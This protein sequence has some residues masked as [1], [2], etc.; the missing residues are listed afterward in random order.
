MGSS[1]D[2]D[3]TLPNVVSDYFFED[4]NDEP[5]SFAELPLK[6]NNGEGLDGNQK[7]IGLRGSTD[8]G[9]KK[10]FEQV[11]A[12]KF[13]ISYSKPEILVLTRKNNWIKLLKPRKSYEERI[14]KILI[15]LHCLNF[16]KRN[17]DTSEK[18]LWDYLAKVFSLYDGRPSE[19]DLEG[20][21][22]LIAEA[23]MRDEVLSRSKVL[24]TL[25]EAKPRKKKV[26]E[27]VGTTTKSS[28]IVD[29]VPN[30][31]D[32]GED[33]SDDEEEDFFEHVCAICDNGGDILCCEGKCMR[34]FHAT[35]EAGAESACESLGFSD[36]QVKAM[37]NQIF[38]C[39]NCQ[40][41]QHQC[42]V[43]GELGSSDK[44]AGA[45]VFQC[46]K[47]TCGYFYHPKC[48]A[49]ALRLRRGDKAK[50]LDE[51]EI[52]AGKSFVCP[53][54]YCS[55]CK[56]LE[57][58]GKSD[59]QMQFAVC[60]RCPNAY[61]RKCLPRRIAFEEDE[62]QGIVQRAWL[63]LMPNKILIYCLE[64]EI[65]DE[66]ATPIRNHIKFPGTDKKKKKQTL[67]LVDKEKVV[68]KKRVLAS[69]D[70]TAKK[71]V[72]KQPK[73]AS[74]TV[75]Q[76]DFS[77]N[78]E[79]RLSIGES[80]KKQKLA[81]NSKAQLKSSFPGKGDKSIGVE[82]KDTLVLINKDSK[83][84]KAVRG[85]A[86]DRKERTKTGGPVSKEA[87]LVALDTD[88]K[89]R[90]LSIMSEAESRITLDDVMEEYKAPST[91]GPS[92]KHVNVMQ[93]IT[94][95]K[96]EASIEA[97]QAAVQKLEGGGRLEDA[98]AVC[99]PGLLNQI[100]KWKQ[101]MK[102]YL[103]P[104]LY[105][106][107]YT[108]FGRHFT[109]VDK[110]QEIV[111]KLHWYV[112]DSDMIVDF[113]CGANDFSCLMKQKLDEMGK[114]CKYKNYDIKPAKND[115]YFEKK[116]WMTVKKND[117]P[118][119][120]EL[121]M[122]LNPP[123]GV[124]AA[125]ANKFINK[126]L[127]FKPKLLILIVPRETIGLDKKRDPYDLVWEDDKLLSGKSFY[128]PGSV[129]VNGKQMEDW[130]VS[131][132]PLYLWS[133]RDW[134]AKHREIA[135]QQ[136]H[137]PH[138]DNMIQQEEPEPHDNCHNSPILATGPDLEDVKQLQEQGAKV[139]ESTSE[140]FCHD[141]GDREIPMDSRGKGQPNGNYKEGNKNQRK[142]RRRSDKKSP[143]GK[144]LP[145]H[146]SP[147]TGGR[148]QDSSKL[149][150]MPSHT[151]VR[152]EGYQHFDQT[153]VSGS[154]MHM[155]RGYDGYQEDGMA[156]R[157]RLSAEEPYLDMGNRWQHPI[158][159][160]SHYGLGAPDEHLVDYQR[161]R[162]SG[163]GHGA[164]FREGNE[165][166]GR[167]ADIRAQARFY[168]HQ[169]PDSMSHRSN[170]PASPAPGFSSSYRQLGPAVH[171]VYNSMNTSAMERY[172]PRL[173]E[174]NPVRMNNVG[175][176][177]HLDGRSGMYN[178]TQLPGHG[179]NPLGFAPGPYRPY[180]QQ[181]SSGWLNE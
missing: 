73:G 167:E 2:E 136:G 157:N 86:S 174:L 169:N 52:A 17:S 142:R 133:R 56:E 132:P 107:R 82:N 83:P 89:R 75:K 109:K 97:L 44:S 25:L 64:H 144:F 139:T 123:F 156:T 119:G 111:D 105:G 50:D 126:A 6:W 26:F 124:N 155:E 28:F 55:R 71:T 16:V 141:R 178:T 131:A 37:A 92:P 43:C 125:L 13:D 160:G 146:S 79:G 140:V 145:Q 39:K 70:A 149:M 120:S 72:A 153:S 54:H 96:V 172:A 4:D 31:D 163:I 22:N 95:G 74:S 181:S 11:T 151:E 116:D 20:H 84:V 60:R 99:E 30:E 148:P 158:G 177:Q 21:M 159:H 130:N 10:I 57:P 91:H 168:G 29:D 118:S 101:K 127:E 1:D 93:S 122:G 165:A 18:A 104:F 36:E 114:R 154:Q 90:I 67:D 76:A 47:G 108:S 179:D 143:G 113:C 147:N 81:D 77:K 38:E 175:S 161:D 27:E 63:D 171:N 68:P 78:N 65:E 176:V 58:E 128:L 98:K 35:L 103:A 162:T 166:Y 19:T 106:M 180:S 48:V 12:W 51:S 170:Y 173:D 129:D 66:L 14:R 135:Q 87:N 46:V 88:S 24:A 32:E 150:E 49:K 61:H 137:L 112:Q 117:L 138:V 9:L 7:E 34:S 53:I 85:E 80:S 94:L 3:E 69:E 121:I 152:R 33:G 23:V 40:Y 5:I 45:E 110:L 41:K 42:F 115:F 15:T 8:N 100:V 59:P 62:D 102:V 134:T 164:Y